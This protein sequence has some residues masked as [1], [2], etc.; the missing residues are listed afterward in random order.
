MRILG[1]TVAAF[2]VGSALL[3]GAPT[4]QAA[5]L[6]VDLS[7]P[8]DALITLDTNTG[9]EW[10]DLTLTVGQSYS[11]VAGGSGGWVGLGFGFADVAQ[12]QTL[13]TDAGIVNFTGTVVPENYQGASLLVSLLGQTASGPSGEQ[14][15]SGYADLV[16]FSA[17]L[18][19]AGGYGV[20]SGNTGS[21]TI[22]NYGMWAKT[23]P[24]PTMGVYMVRAAPTVPEPA[25]IALLGL[26][27]VGLGFSRRKRAN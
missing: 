11:A 14:L 5:L 3:I 22:T 12:V 4:T 8:G 19:G 1:K 26:G 7:T 10:L 9:L 24:S 20:F 18:V 25:T 2:A 27:L 6:P 13:F 17:T 21:A 16:P 15:G 23:Q